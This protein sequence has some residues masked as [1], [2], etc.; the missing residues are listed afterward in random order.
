MA[1]KKGGAFS[2]TMKDGAKLALRIQKIKD[3]SETAIRRTVSDFKSRAPG[4]ISKGVRQ[5]YGVD[6]AAIKEAGPRVKSGATHVHISGAQ[7][8]AA[9]LEYKGGMLTTTHFSQSPKGANPKGFKKGLQRIPGQYT[10]SGSPVVFSK[11]PKE[12]KIKVRI[13]KGSAGV[14]PPGT[15]IATHGATLPFQRT[16]EARKPILPVKTISVPQMVSSDRA[17]ETVNNLINENLE[18]RFEH[19]VQQ[20]LKSL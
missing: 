15:F 19:H 16:S 2:V 12:Y 20:A 13:L 18:K 6:T 17:K 9:S 4:W 5:F 14:L 7:I 3:G 11:V 1:G 10:S 8:D